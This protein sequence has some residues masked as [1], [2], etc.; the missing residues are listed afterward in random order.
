MLST[1]TRANA[2]QTLILAIRHGETDW[3]LQGRYQGQTDIGLNAQGREQASQ[4]AR[5]LADV[6]LDAIYASDLA[7][8]A[9][10]AAILAQPHGLPVCLLSSLREQHFGRFQG[11]SAAEI[12][13]RWPEDAARW[14]RREPGFGPEGGESRQAFYTRCLAALAE[15][16]GRHRGQCVALVCHGGVLDCLYRAA[17]DLPLDAPRRWPLDNAAVSRLLYGPQGLQLLE[18][19]GTAHLEGARDDLPDRFPA[20]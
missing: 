13:Q 9:D 2:D 10:T 7:R 8:A 14:E 17:A 16:A 3:N 5:A 12:A 6:R 4:A 18:W 11:L 19:G 1:S 15:L 20:P